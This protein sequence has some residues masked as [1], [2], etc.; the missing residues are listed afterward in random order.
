MAVH[1]WIARLARAGVAVRH[2]RATL[3]PAA[4]GHTRA[5]LYVGFDDGATAVSSSV[6]PEP[7]VAIAGAV[8]ALR[9][10]RLARSPVGTPLART[11]QTAALAV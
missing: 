8:R 9:Q 3:G 2:V 5:V 10:Q 11:T 4:R 6:H 7:Y 1:H